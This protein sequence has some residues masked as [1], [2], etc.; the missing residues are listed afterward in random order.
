MK[1]TNKEKHLIK[2]GK[3]IE[4]IN[5]CRD[6]KVPAEHIFWFVDKLE[7]EKFSLKSD[8]T[9]VGA[10]LVLKMFKKSSKFKS[11]EGSLKRA[12]FKASQFVETDE[13]E[14]SRILETF[15][16]GYY[17]Q[18]L[19]HKELYFE[20][21]AMRNCVFDMS[22]EVKS[23]KIA[24]LALK[25]SKSKTICHIQVGI[26]GNLEQHYQ[27]ANSEVEIDAWIYINKFFEKYKSI[28]IDEIMLQKN[29]T[30]LYS[31]NNFYPFNVRSYLPTEKRVSLLDDD[32]N[33]VYNIGKICLK[34]YSLQPE[35]ATKQQEL[36][37]YENIMSEI[38][39]LKNKFLKQINDLEKSLE[40]SEKNFFILNDD[41][42]FKIFGKKI[43]YKKRLTNLMSTMIGKS[44]LIENPE[45]Q[46]T[47][48]VRQELF[49]DFFRTPDEGDIDEG[50]IADF[51]EEDV[52]REAEEEVIIDELT[53]TEDIDLSLF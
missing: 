17:I 45:E 9:R 2:S 20:S 12:I 1:L 8:S 11:N 33:G 27:F 40:V 14:R 36:M 30:K 38:G 42:Y 3:K 53:E 19:T 44:Q 35:K 23:K 15:D 22:S 18:L 52:I 26:N 28:E 10:S 7:K 46:V 39:M 37:S 50:D 5:F 4:T 48:P 34:D 16:K 31:L 32:V 49:D 43:K 21:K 25:N 24:I 29:I 6:I 51:F 41:M 13:S 47:R